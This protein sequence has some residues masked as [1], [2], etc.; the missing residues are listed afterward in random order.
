M[1]MQSMLSS[2]ANS[3]SSNE[4]NVDAFFFKWFTSFLNN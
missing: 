4:L 2:A 1:S 3:I